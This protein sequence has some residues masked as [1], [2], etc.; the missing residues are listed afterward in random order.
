MFWRRVDCLARVQQT[1]FYD[2]HC[3]RTHGVMPKFRVGAPVFESYSHVGRDNWP[4]LK[5]V[6]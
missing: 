2:K 5:S 4:D 1:R 3:S 6:P